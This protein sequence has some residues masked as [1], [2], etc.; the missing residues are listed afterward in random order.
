MEQRQ[1]GGGS[2]I[3]ATIVMLLILAG[4]LFGFHVRVQREVEPAQRPYAYAAAFV[5]TFLVWRWRRRA[6]RAH[7]LRRAAAGA[8]RIEVSEPGLSVQ[9]SGS[10]GQIPWS[11]FSRCLESPNLFLLVNRTKSTVLVI[12]KRAFPDEGTQDWFHTLATNQLSLADRPPAEPPPLA[13]SIAEDAVQ[14]KI[15]LRYRDYLDRTLA[16]WRTWGFFIA[17]A[18]L[19]AVTGL[20]VLLNPPPN[21][22]V[23]A[24][25]ALF[26]FML[27]FLV[28]MLALMIL[29]GSAHTWWT[30]SRMA[31]SQEVALSEKSI[32][33]SGSDAIGT[34]PWTA[35]T[36]YKETRWSFILWNS[37]T[38]AWT[39][40]PK[41]LFTSSSDRDRCR[42]L[43]GCHLQ[44][45]RWFT[46]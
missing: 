5:L 44:E 39:M 16:S 24:T 26:M 34:L 25:Q 11:A 15:R 28:L 19:C 22:A 33:F 23:L 14:L 13:P 32:A 4:M 10:E 2:K 35:F 40:F 3:L 7:R 17:M 18:A 9:G 8:T 1:F 43:L 29:V 21:A 41:R 30:C 37:R 20:F 6:R 45:S 42:E 46:G 38:S 31:V 12:P 27:Q 36:N